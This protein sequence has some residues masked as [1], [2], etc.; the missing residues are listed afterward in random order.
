MSLISIVNLAERL[1]NHSSEQDQGAQTG[2]P[3]NRVSANSQANEA[4][5]EF[6]PSKS[7]PNTAQEAG[8]F[9]ATTLSFFTAAA[10]FLLGQISK[11]QT[12]VDAPTTTAQNNQTP[13]PSQSSATTN[14]VVDSTI[15]QAPTAVS[16]APLIIANPAVPQSS[17]A[18][19]VAA[20][21]QNEIQALNSDLTALGLSPADIRII[22]R[23]ASLIRDFNPT[24][25]ST[26]VYQLK[27]LA[28][29]N[30]AGSTSSNTNFRSRRW[31]F[32]LQ[33]STRT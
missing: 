17:A 21:T 16:T 32:A 4:G 27:A 2:L 22:D 30:A 19:S 31:K 3:T 33:A 13:L 8:L 9:S 24:V 12:N 20:S 28:E 18:S 6:T 15:L 5:D 1:L 14:S 25:F 11:P 7:N 23:I 29:A 26:F 10:D